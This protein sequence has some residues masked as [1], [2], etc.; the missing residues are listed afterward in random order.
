M[1]NGFSAGESMNARKW[2]RISVAL[3][4]RVRF[5]LR[6]ESIQARTVNISREGIFI[7]L[8]PPRSIGTM[9]RVHISIAETREEFALEGIVVHRIPDEGQALATGAVA[10]IGVFVTSASEGYVQFCDEIAAARR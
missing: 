7:A 6:S 10:G 9:V 5:Q 1:A 4:V 8:D 2:P 3:S